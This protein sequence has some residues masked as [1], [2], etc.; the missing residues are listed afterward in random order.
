MK[1]LLICP[2]QASGI[3]VLADSRPAATLPFLGETFIGCWM[4]HLARQKF[5]E[6]RI[7]TSD[8]VESIQDY[9]G[10]GSRWGLT[11]EIRHEARDLAPD[12]ARARHRAPDET[13]WP[14]APGDLIEADHLPG[15]PEHKLFAS[16]GHFFQALR[17][18]LPRVV[19]SQ[20][21]GMRE[22]QPGVW[23]GRKTHVD[24]SAVLTGPCWIGENARIGRNAVVGPHSYLEDRVVLDEHCEVA[25]SWIAPDT[26]L[27]ALTHVK[28]SLAWGDLLINWRSESHTLVRDSFVMSSLAD[29]KRRKPKEA[30]DA[31]RIKTKDARPFA[32]VISLTQKLQG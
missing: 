17:L 4:R 31:A 1:T 27:G 12:E 25:S 29:E 22:L 26:F 19:E 5:Q 13:G 7:I 21:I 3:P 9:V 15:F 16:Y 6:V 11:V 2:Y 28:E 8:S 20:P 30:P 14:E 23:V 18:W 24:S 32:P 10:D